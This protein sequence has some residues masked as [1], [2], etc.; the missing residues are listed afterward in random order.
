MSYIDFQTREVM[1]KPSFGESFKYKEEYSRDNP[2][3]ISVLKAKWLI[4]HVVLL[5]LASVTKTNKANIECSSIPVV[6]DL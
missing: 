3:I 1:F 5:F 6:S 4:R 2:K